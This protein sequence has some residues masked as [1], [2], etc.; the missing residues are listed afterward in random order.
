MTPLA[1][2]ARR[3]PPA[4]APS[5]PTSRDAGAAADVSSPRRPRAAPSLRS[6]PLRPSRAPP[7]AADPDKLVPVADAG[8]GDVDEDFACG[9][10]RQ[11]VYLED[12]DGLA[13]CCDSGRSHPVRCSLL[14]SV[15]WRGPRWHLAR[16]VRR[17][18]SDRWLAGA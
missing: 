1:A 9:R 2:G 14:A 6:L 3:S 16:E 13:E 17:G 15:I 12:L 4:R 10:R 8:G 5:P 18:S 11:L 7:P